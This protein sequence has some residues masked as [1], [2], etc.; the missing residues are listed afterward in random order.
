M[1]ESSFHFPSGWE[2]QEAARAAQL[3]AEAHK[4]PPYSFYFCGK[5]R[6]TDWRHQLLAFNQLRD[7]PYPLLAYRSG[8]APVIQH[9]LGPN[10]HYA[11]PYFIGCDHGCYHGEGTHGAGVNKDTCC[12]D[13]GLEFPMPL[14]DFGAEVTQNCLFSI[15]NASIVFAWLDNLSAYGSFAELG[16]A[17]GIGKPIWLA[18]PKPLPELWFLRQM[19]SVIVIAENPSLA[20]R[21]LLFSQLG[22]RLL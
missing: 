4:H 20:F 3:E 6:H 15:A 19:A 21:E 7:T 14:G 16:F 5:I 12:C 22:R 13:D 1:P 8:H 18:W 9:G 10:L 2:A 11:G 17:H